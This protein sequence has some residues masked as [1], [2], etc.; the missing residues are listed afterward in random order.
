MRPVLVSREASRSAL[1]APYTHLLPSNQLRGVTPVRGWPVYSNAPI[2]PF[3]FCFSAARQPYFLQMFLHPEK[4]RLFYCELLRSRAA[5]KQKG[6]FRS[7]GL[8]KSGNPLACCSQKMRPRCSRPVRLGPLC[9]FRNRSPI[10]E[11]QQR[12]RT[13]TFTSHDRCDRNAVAR[14]TA[15]LG[16]AI[17]LP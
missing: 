5:E 12:K 2:P 7:F 17:N 15:L 11:L 9:R 3:S 14:C 13:L 6:S 1:S 4:G 16:W 8:C 10:R